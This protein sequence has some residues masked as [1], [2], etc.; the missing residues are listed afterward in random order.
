MKG[1][2]RKR[3]ENSYEIH[4]DLPRGEDGRRNQIT[5]TI[6]GK[7]SA[8]AKRLANA[9]LIQ[10]NHEIL[11]GTA[12]EPNKITV[13]EYFRTWLKHSAKP[14]VSTASY[15]RY[16][17]V[18]EKYVIPNIGSHKLEKLKPLHIQA[19][20][21]KSLERVS[22]RTIQFN[23]RVVHRA[24]EMAVKWQ[25]L[26]RNPADAVDIPRGEQRQI[27]PLSEDEIVKLLESARGTRFYWPCL[28][29]LSTGMRLG[30][31]L[32]LSWNDLDLENRI[33]H[34]RR[35]LT[36][37]PEGKTEFKL[38][39]SGKSR[40]VVIPVGTADELRRL[41]L[42]RNAYESNDVICQSIKGTP[43]NPNT[44]GVAFH[45]FVTRIGL[46]CRFHDLRHTFATQLLEKGATLKTISEILGH[47]NIG[48]TGNVYT[49]NT[50]TMREHAAGLINDVLFT[51]KNQK[52]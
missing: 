4:I 22:A 19:M 49:H 7:N 51:P 34:V 18:V 2:I 48:I 47:A 13:A 42:E 25:L 12:I 20:H 30:E 1:S 39:K 45:R 32:A 3:G 33:C 37:M 14:S 16:K 9:R 21:T 24:L 36:R 44:F 11:T 27:Q 10:L 8:D 50:D 6:R 5:E 41:R 38:P 46:N 29:A 28:L 26:S 52:C 35:S 43:E 40:E 17:I 23:H 15:I 31:V